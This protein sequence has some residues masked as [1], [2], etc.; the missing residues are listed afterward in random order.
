MHDFELT[1]SNSGS[2]HAQIRDLFATVAPYG[3]KGC[4]GS[5]LLYSRIG[6][7]EVSKCSGMCQSCSG[8][9]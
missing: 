8:A 9:S 3:R 6:V 7:Q 1:V 2:A 5:S 4:A